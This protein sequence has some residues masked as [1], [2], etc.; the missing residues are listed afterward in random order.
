MRN[1][2]ADWLHGLGEGGVRINHNEHYRTIDIPDPW[3]EVLQVYTDRVGLN[4]LSAL[5][6][7]TRGSTDH[8]PYTSHGWHVPDRRKPIV[9]A[10]AVSSP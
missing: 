5:E 9:V 1:L 4:A 10:D 6:D 2:I 8:S 7:L 3:T